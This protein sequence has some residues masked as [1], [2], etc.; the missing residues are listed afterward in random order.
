MNNPFE[1]YTTAQL[2]A[3]S[4]CLKSE[5]KTRKDAPSRTK[6]GEDSAEFDINGSSWLVSFAV[7]VSKP[8]LVSD[9]KFGRRLATV[10][11]YALAREQVNDVCNGEE[12]DVSKRVESLIADHGSAV[13]LDTPI[14]DKIEAVYQEQRLS[15]PKRIGKGQ[16]RLGK[17]EVK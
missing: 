8:K 15:F 5:L 7:S 1:N 6:A 2:Q 12:V 9:S 17:M 14:S 10:L 3:I 4:L 13:G 11:A 16:T